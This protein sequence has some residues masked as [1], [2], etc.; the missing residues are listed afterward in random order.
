MK[1]FEVPTT[2]EEMNEALTKDLMAYGHLTKL[3]SS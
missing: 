1:M 2:L 3:T